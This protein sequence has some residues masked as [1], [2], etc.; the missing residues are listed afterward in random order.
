M[1]LVVDLFDPTRGPY[2][3]LN[4]IVCDAAGFESYREELWG[5]MSLTRRGARFFP[6]INGADLFVYPEDLTEFV[7][8]CQ[9]IEAESAAIA[10]EIWGPDADGE[11]I[12]EY[13]RRFID[14]I[15]IAR[16]RNAGVCIS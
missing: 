2:S 10:T 1:T 5:S 9:M 11:N 16:E 6:K 12:R 3:Y 15:R 4:A 8:E 14:V 13:M 7:A